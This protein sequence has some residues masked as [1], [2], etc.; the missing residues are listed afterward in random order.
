MITTNDKVGS[1]KVLADDGVPDGFSWSTHTHSKRK[2]S[3]SS[4]SIGVSADDCFVDTNTSESVDISRFGKANDR[5]DENVGV[6]LT[7]SAD[8]QFSV[9]S[10]HGVSSLE[11]N[12]VSPGQLLEESTRFSWGVAKSNIV[13]VIWSVDGFDVT[14]NVEFLDSVVE[15][16]D[17][18]VSH[19]I[20]TKDLFGFLVFVWLVDVAD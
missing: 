1:T 11:S 20:S 19:V 10:V 15:V 4:H 13:V 8:G 18:G 14:A 16:G 2:K 6:S 3:Q 7:S 17:S 12:D 5:V 9:C